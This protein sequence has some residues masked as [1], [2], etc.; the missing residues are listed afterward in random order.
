[1]PMSRR[2]MA[3]GKR[4]NSSATAKAAKTSTT[5]RALNGARRRLRLVGY[6]LLAVLGVVILI[7]GYLAVVP[8]NLGALAS[9]AAPIDNYAQAS[10]RVLALQAQEQGINPECAS[11][12]LTHGEKTAKVIVFIHGYTNCP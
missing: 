10:A 7:A 2:R 3:T 9:H 1:M 8:P 5:T 6:V 12:L 4:P 11:Q